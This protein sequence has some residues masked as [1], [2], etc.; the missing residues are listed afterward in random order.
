MTEP[1]DGYYTRSELEAMKAEAVA[2]E[3][4]RLQ[5]EIVTWKRAAGKYV[6]DCTNVD[7]AVAAERERCARIC[8]EIASRFDMTVGE[9][10][11]ATCAAAIREGE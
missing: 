4:E 5:D 8:D 11:A 7:E 2:A 1:Y 3:R 6:A 10:P 9:C